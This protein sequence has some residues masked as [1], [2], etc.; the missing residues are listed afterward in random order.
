MLSIEFI[1]G[2]SVIFARWETAC[3]ICAGYGAC[4]W[5]LYS[6][7]LSISMR[8]CFHADVPVGSGFRINMLS[9]DSAQSLPMIAT[10]SPLVGI[11]EAMDLGQSY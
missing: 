3:S 2:E 6:F 8:G 4:M 9:N 1:L 10:K 7:V 5:G 11:V